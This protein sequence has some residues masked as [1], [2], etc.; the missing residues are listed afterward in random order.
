MSLGLTHEEEEALREQ[1]EQMTSPEVVEDTE[2]ESAPVVEDDA[3]EVEDSHPDE[4]DAVVDEDST[5]E[6][7]AGDAETTGEIEDDSEEEPTLVEPDLFTV[8]VNGEELQVPL[9]ELTRGYQTMRAA[10]EK[11]EAASRIEKESSHLIEFAQQFDAAFQENPAGLLAEY[12]ELMDDPNTVI[13][14]LVERSAALGKLHPQLV[15]LFGIDDTYVAKAEAQMERSRRERIEN[16]RSVETAEQAD[17]FGYTATQY[18]EIA[19]ELIAAAGLSDTDDETKLNFVREF[20][21]FRSTNNI[22]NPYIAFARWAESTARQ[23]AEVAKAEAAKAAATISATRKAAQPKQR[24]P[25][26]A[27]TSGQVAAVES[28]V[29]GP[30]AD[31]YEAAKAAFEKVFGN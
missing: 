29:D 13:L 25:G 27:A 18:N 15:E 10:N 24:I 7:E 4:Q 26:A 19:D 1:I 16:E 30:I 5:D 31:H 12:V 28:V 6:V 17:Q 22:A 9:E 3:L 8:K 21:S 11:F 23:E 20:S 2:A 14:A